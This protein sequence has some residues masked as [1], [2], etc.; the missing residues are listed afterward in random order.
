MQNSY[1]CDSHYQDLLLNDPTTEFHRGQRPAIVRNLLAS[2][3]LETHEDFLRSN[4]SISYVKKHDRQNEWL[5]EDDYLRKHNSMISQRGT[6]SHVDHLASAEDFVRFTSYQYAKRGD[7]DNI[8]SREYK[9]NKTSAS[10]PRKNCLQKETSGNLKFRQNFST[11]SRQ[12]LDKGVIEF[13]APKNY[14]NSPVTVCSDNCLTNPS[15]F[16]HKRCFIIDIG[17]LLLLNNKKLVLEKLTDERLK[18]ELFKF[19][20]LH[21]NSR[22]NLIDFFLNLVF[23]RKGTLSQKS[24]VV[25]VVVFNARSENFKK[26]GDFKCNPRLFPNFFTQNLRDSLYDLEEN[27]LNTLEWWVKRNFHFDTPFNAASVIF[28]K[29]LR[30]FLKF[31]RNREQRAASYVCYFRRFIISG[32][33]HFFGLNLTEVFNSVRIIG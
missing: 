31:S 5:D 1:P 12:G 32:L 22:R 20:T 26:C 9:V 3:S 8:E 25:Y 28:D 6:F 21:D 18:L 24:L 7:I 27:I 13:H 14:N 19:L 23:E 30:E 4:H 29:V 10:N 11:L 2:D 15:L 33:C 16:D 17:A